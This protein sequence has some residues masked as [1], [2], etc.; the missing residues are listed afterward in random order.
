MQDINILSDPDNLKKHCQIHK[1]WDATASSTTGESWILPQNG[2][3]AVPWDANMV[4]DRSALHLHSQPVLKI[5]HGGDDHRVLDVVIEE[6]VL[7][8]RVV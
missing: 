7:H 8:V 4:D 2:E 6:H 3:G 5:L 1:S